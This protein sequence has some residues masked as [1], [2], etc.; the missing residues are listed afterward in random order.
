MVTKC[1]CT[2]EE[3]VVHKTIPEARDSD[4]DAFMTLR[5]ADSRS[6]RANKCANVDAV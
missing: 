2:R 5:T 6:N 3:D 4:E 1:N